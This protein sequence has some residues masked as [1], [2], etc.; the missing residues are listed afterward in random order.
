VISVQINSEES[1]QIAVQHDANQEITAYLN[2]H[3]S[4]RKALIFIDERVAKFHISDYMKLLNGT[5][6]G[7][8]GLTTIPE[9]ESSKSFSMYEQLVSEA[10]EADLKRSDVI[11]AIGGGVTGDLAGFVAATVLRGVHLIHLPTSLLAMVDSSVG[12]KTGI[13]HTTGKNRIGAF[14]QPDAIFM[15]LKRLETLEQKEWM[16]GFGEVLKYGCISNPEIIDSAKKS[17]AQKFVIDENVRSIIESSVK[18]K[19]DIVQQDEKES[20]IRAF[21][22]FGHTTAHA[23][24]RV[25]EYGTVAHGVAVFMGMITELEL[26]RLKG[27]L[28]R[29]DQL[30][31]LVDDYRDYVPDLKNLAINDLIQAMSYDKKNM[32]AGT[33]F[34]LLNDMAQPYVTSD[35]DQQDISRSLSLMINRFS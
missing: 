23:I 21:L 7:S 26:S 15:E 33:T 13:N 28:K 4:G 32:A 8:V 3:F 34:V 29:S 1:Y 14:Y 27:G 35:V 18:I 19:A 11:I 30:D 12:G 31:L 16:A 5:K 24:E 22:N 9:G 2:T 20:G 10:L 6:L 25:M 17:I